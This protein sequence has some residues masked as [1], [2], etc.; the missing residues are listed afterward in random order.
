M[1]QRAHRSRSM[2]ITFVVVGVIALGQTAWA[3]PD[4]TTCECPSL[5]GAVQKAVTLNIPFL[6]AVS[7]DLPD[8]HDVSGC[9]ATFDTMQGAVNAA[10]GFGADVVIGV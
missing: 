8:S 3:A 9:D 7:G 2:W 5:P 4:P 6:A 1:K 10:S